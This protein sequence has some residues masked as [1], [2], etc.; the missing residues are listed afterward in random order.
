MRPELIFLFTDLHPCFKDGVLDSF[1][2][3]AIFVP[4]VS[5]IAELVACGGDTVAFVLSPLFVFVMFY[6]L[7]ERDLSNTF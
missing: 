1:S 4:L 5:V 3:A 7:I 2:C 6:A